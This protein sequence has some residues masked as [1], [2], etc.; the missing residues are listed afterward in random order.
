MIFVYYSSK[1]FLPFS[2]FFWKQRSRT[3]VDFGA[4]PVIFEKVPFQKGLKWTRIGYNN[5]TLTSFFFFFFFFC[6]RF[7]YVPEK[8]PVSGYVIYHREDHCHLLKRIA[9]HL[10]DGKFL[11]IDTLKFKDALKCKD[12]TL[13]KSGL[14]EAAVNGTH[15]QSVSDAERLL[16]HAVAEYMSAKNYKKEAEYIKVIADWHEASDGRG[17]TQTQRSDANKKMKTYIMQRWM[18]WYDSDNDLSKIDFNV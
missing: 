14:T 4:L 5:F 9:K 18:P 3:P 12:K 1:F 10:R 15:K 11:E 8:C 13:P 2:D 6:Y 16:S 7:L 17:L